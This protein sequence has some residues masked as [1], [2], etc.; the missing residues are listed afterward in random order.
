[1]VLSLRC[2]QLCI[3]TVPQ[4]IPYHTRTHSAFL[5]FLILF[6]IRQAVFLPSS[7]FQS[8]A[9]FLPDGPAADGPAGNSA[10]SV[11]RPALESPGCGKHHR[12]RPA[13]ALIA[14]AGS[15]TGGATRHGSARW[16]CAAGGAGS[17]RLVE[18][19]A[20]VQIK[21]SN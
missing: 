14:G 5:N 17:D 4:S 15:T 13:A 21:A 3:G 1:M 2:R 7:T 11:G 20:V 16:L 18:L 10:P 19:F 8:A 9:P 12:R 6:P